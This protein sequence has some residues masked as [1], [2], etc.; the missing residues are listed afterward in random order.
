MVDTYRGEGKIFSARPSLAGGNDVVM[1]RAPGSAS[2]YSG[3]R[4]P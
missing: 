3:Q 1:T 2:P 4:S